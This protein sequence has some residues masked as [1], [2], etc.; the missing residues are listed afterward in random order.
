[1]RPRDLCLHYRACCGTAY[2]PLNAPTGFFTGVAATSW[3]CD[4][5][6]WNDLIGSLGDGRALAKVVAR[7]AN[8]L[9]AIACRGCNNCLF[10]LGR[11]DGAKDWLSEDEL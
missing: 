7:E 1:M 6:V 4:R 3:S 10:S 5:V 2:P 11:K 8:N 9:D